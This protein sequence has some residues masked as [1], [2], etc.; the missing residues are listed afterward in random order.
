[1]ASLKSASEQRQ[2]SP[3]SQGKL[4]KARTDLLLEMRPG[5]G[6]FRQGLEKSLL[7]IARMGQVGG[8]QVHSVDRLARKP[9][10]PQA[11]PPSL[12]EQFDT[13]DGSQ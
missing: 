13:I 1:M 5:P 10:F 11:I 2:G 8:Q 4:P 7:H 12:H 6:P 3:L 9:G